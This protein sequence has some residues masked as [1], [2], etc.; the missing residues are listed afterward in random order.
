MAWLRIGPYKRLAPWKHWLALWVTLAILIVIAVT[1]P[2]T[3]T[4]CYEWAVGQRHDGAT[5]VA[6]RICEQR[7]GDLDDD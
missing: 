5:R 1:Y 2:W 3:K 7:F 6:Y 4:Q